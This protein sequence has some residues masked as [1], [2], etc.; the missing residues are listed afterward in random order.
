MLVDAYRNDTTTALATIQRY[1]ATLQRTAFRAQDQLLALRKLDAQTARQ[2]ARRN[3]PKFTPNPTP[4]TPPI[5]ADNIP[6]QPS[7]RCSSVA[8][9]CSH[10]DP[11]YTSDRT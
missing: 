5:R 6:P 11:P 2:A 4:P 1:A 9:P 7:Y 10:P 8:N 3:E